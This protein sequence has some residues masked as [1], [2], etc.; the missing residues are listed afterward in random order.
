MADHGL[1]G[2]SLKPRQTDQ[3][4][5][6]SQ[7]PASFRFFCGLFRLTA[8]S[9]DLY[10]WF[11]GEE[12]RLPAKRSIR[13]AEKDRISDRESQTGWNA[14]QPRFHQRQRPG[15]TVSKRADVSQTNF[16]FR[17]AAAGMPE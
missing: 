3:S 4:C 14:P 7:S 17:A 9:R 12:S 2:L 6:V 1:F 10:D 15:N 11:A 5:M 8:D 13:Q 16:D